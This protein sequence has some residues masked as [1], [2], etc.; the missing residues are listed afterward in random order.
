MY[1]AYKTKNGTYVV[2]SNLTEDR[3]G[4]DIFCDLSFAQ[5]LLLVRYIHGGTVTGGEK[6]EIDDLIANN[7]C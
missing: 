1:Q 7:E 5:A 2:N 4:K 6:T 3:Y